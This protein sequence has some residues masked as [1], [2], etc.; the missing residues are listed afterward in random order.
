MNNSYMA[1]IPLFHVCFMDY[2]KIEGSITLLQFPTSLPSISPG[3]SIDSRWAAYK[4]EKDQE[5]V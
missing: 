1:E 2:I 4:R 5:I 3:F